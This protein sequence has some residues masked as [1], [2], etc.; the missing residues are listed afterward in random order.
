MAG[1]TLPARA[2]SSAASDAAGRRR[3]HG[4]R[5]ADGFDVQYVMPGP[6]DQQIFRKEAD[7]DG[8]GPADDME[9]V[10]VK[11]ERA[12]Q[13]SG[14]IARGWEMVRTMLVNAIPNPD[15][16]REHP[17]FFVCENCRWWLEYVPP[18]PRDPDDQDVHPEGYEDHLSDMTRYRLNWE[19]PGMWRKA[20]F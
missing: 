1:R 17:G 9:E 5:S 13:S 20:G 15:G 4:L 19:P 6:A 8:I 14:S 16:T 3:T 7:R 11:W 2:R 12:D 10:G 18:T